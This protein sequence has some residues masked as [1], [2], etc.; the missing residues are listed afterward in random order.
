MG[1]GDKDQILMDNL[2]IFKCY[3]EKIIREFPNKGWE[4]QEMN[5]LLKKAAINWHDGKMKWQ[6]WKHTESF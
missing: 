3:G 4:L 2:Y 5:K 1:F 6:H